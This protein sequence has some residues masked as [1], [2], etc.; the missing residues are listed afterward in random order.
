MAQGCGSEQTPTHGK[1][2][3][4]PDFTGRMQGWGN[5]W[6]PLLPPL[7]VPLLLQVCLTH[8]SCGKEGRGK[9]LGDKEGKRRSS[10][11]S[12]FEGKQI[13]VPSTALPY[14]SYMI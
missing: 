14:A 8:F 7:I 3:Q 2:T 4:D 10:L 5:G 13:R 9:M 11:L 12:F 1:T 6:G